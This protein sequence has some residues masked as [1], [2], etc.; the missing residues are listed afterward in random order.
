MNNK[1]NKKYSKQSF[2]RFGD[3]LC[4]LLLSYLSISDKIRFE[5]VSK[6]WQRL[7]FNS[8]FKLIISGGEG[9]HTISEL[10]LKSKKFKHLFNL[11][12]DSFE[13]LLKKLK[14]INEIVID[15]YCIIDGQIVEYIY[16]NCV[17]LERFVCT[18]I[19]IENFSETHLRQFCAKC[20][21]KLKLI[22]FDG[23]NEIEMR[24]ILR[25]SP[26]IRSVNIKNNNFITRIESLFIHS[27]TKQLL[28]PKLDSIYISCYCV[29][30]LMAFADKYSQQI[31]KIEIKFMSN[32]LIANVMN[33]AL[34][35]ISRFV[36]LET[37]Y[38]L[39]YNHQ[40]GPIYPIDD[41]LQMIAIKC[42]KLKHF[43]CEMTQNLV[44]GQLFEVF[45]N[46]TSLQTCKISTTYEHHSDYGS[47]T[48]LKYCSNL[49][50]LTLYLKYL[51]DKH[52]KDIHLYLPKLKSFKL[53]T[54]NGFIT[55]QT[56][57][58]LAK[59]RK[60]S[61]IEISGITSSMFKITDAAVCN[62]IINCPNLKSVSLF[63]KTNVTQKVI[64]TFVNRAHLYPKQNYQF[65]YQRNDFSHSQTNS[66]TNTESDAK[67]DSINPLP[68]N[69]FIY[70]I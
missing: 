10:L 52:F 62:T 33:N 27:I 55:D 60:L 14:S 38:L 59:L 54:S 53:N 12:K 2:D 51:S 24:T 7:I 4:Q 31:K 17:H 67:F 37:L 26:N 57:H 9:N 47:I 48:D 21:Q 49:T 64:D 20:G 44:S 41:G 28:S 32:Y 23:I 18:S 5:C 8:Q 25:L 69:L 19:K 36:N 61:V 13:I 65:F 29:D 68:H 1:I 63:C 56:L 45:S 43:I 11:K 3:D 42:T 30:D 16:D 22:Q 35:Q 58:C 40:K 50:H 70:S 15:N 46:F 34:K 6:Q 66:H 39:I